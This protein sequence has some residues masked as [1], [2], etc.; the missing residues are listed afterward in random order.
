MDSATQL[1]P[2]KYIYIHICI[3]PSLFLLSLLARPAPRLFLSFIFIHHRLSTR[4][5]TS[6]LSSS[7][8]RCH[9]Y[10]HSCAARGG[11]RPRLFVRFTLNRSYFLSRLSA[12]TP[13][14][15]VSAARSRFCLSP[16]RTHA[17]TLRFPPCP[18]PLSPTSGV[19][20]AP[21][22]QALRAATRS[23]RRGHVD[24]LRSLVRLTSASL[25]FACGASSWLRG[26]AQRSAK[27][28][29]PPPL[30]PYRWTPQHC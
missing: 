29:P 18:S 16:S 10:I 21:R 22:Q 8:G 27:R 13:S 6:V 20:V 12:V 30:P 19:S 7:L 26:A 15:V 1:L 2:Q 23:T 28:R 9:T 11:E 3:F 25:R 5:S 14:S 17:R 4:P 24:S